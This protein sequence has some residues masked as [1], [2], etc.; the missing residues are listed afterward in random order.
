MMEDMQDNLQVVNSGGNVE[1]I[2]YTNSLGTFVSGEAPIF[3]SSGNFVAKETVDI[4]FLCTEAQ[5]LYTLVNTFIVL[6]IGI[7]IIALII[8]ELISWART[9][10]LKKKYKEQKVKNLEEYLMEKHRWR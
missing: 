3:D 8:F 7:I 4:D 2:K 5:I 1:I 6:L 9:R 10:E